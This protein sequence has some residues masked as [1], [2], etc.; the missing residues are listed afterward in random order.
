MFKNIFS[1]FPIDSGDNWQLPRGM[2]IASMEVWLP[3]IGGGE[4]STIGPQTRMSATNRIDV[5]SY[6]PKL[7]DMPYKFSTYLPSPEN[8][9]LEIISSCSLPLLS[10]T[11]A[12]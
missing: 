8:G 7:L 12:K 3:H 1:D 5:W 10:P 6:S 9:R 2:K 11:E 4:A